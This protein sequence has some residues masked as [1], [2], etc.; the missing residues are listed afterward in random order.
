MILS[1]GIKMNPKKI[2]EYTEKEKIL[3]KDILD[4]GFCLSSDV[5]EEPI[6][7]EIATYEYNNAIYYFRIVTGKVVLFKKLSR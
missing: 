4:N 5:F 3:I 6:Y 1:G 2:Y 7:V